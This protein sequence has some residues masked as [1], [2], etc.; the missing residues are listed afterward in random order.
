MSLCG[1]VAKI[2]YC[3]YEGCTCVYTRTVQP[4]VGFVCKVLFATISHYTARIVEK[5][6]YPFTR[7]PLQT[8]RVTTVAS[9]I[10]P[11]TT[12]LREEERIDLDCSK[13]DGLEEKKNSEREEPVLPIQVGKEEKHSELSAPAALE[14]IKIFA[15]HSS[16]PFYLSRVG[17]PNPSFRNC[18]YNSFS[19]ICAHTGYRVPAIHPKNERLFNEWACSDAEAFK[20][21]LSLELAECKKKMIGEERA[22]QEIRERE[23]GELAAMESLVQRAKEAFEE[24][25][26]QVEKVNLKEW[27]ISKSDEDQELKK[28]KAEYKR[29]PNEALR[30]AIYKLEIEI[31][32][33]EVEQ[34][35]FN[36]TIL[37]EEEASKKDLEWKKDEWE[38]R[39]KDLTDAKMQWAS[40]KG[41]L[42]QEIKTIHS[43]LKAVEKALEDQESL[44]RGAAILAILRGEMPGILTMEDAQLLTAI[45]ADV[46]RGRTLYQG[47]EDV[48]KDVER[49][50][51]R[52]ALYDSDWR[53]LRVGGYGHWWVYLRNADGLTIDEINDA[54]SYQK[55]MTIEA[56][57]E[58]Y[59][60]PDEW[61]KTQI[62]V[63][64]GIEERESACND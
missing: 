57:F 29:N 28:I 7:A 43:Q 16:I 23:N 44:K 31:N 21:A 40:E 62:T 42:E 15:N 1:S 35:M 2:G 50:K 34:V 41:A 52:Q 63:F 61:S 32:R 46:M 26:L 14:T 33:R 4:L 27:T 49:E 25:Q 30:E 59:S 54:N 10:F 11:F 17:F 8:S 60:H 20:Q 39:E 18:S 9:A 37:R 56:L 48:Q 45:F 19:V 6:S 12:A 47:P 64:E 5:V 55:R 53:A 3:L 58:K 22:L 51:L 38:R 24:R 13:G 36:K